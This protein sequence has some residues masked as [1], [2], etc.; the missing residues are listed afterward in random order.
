[1]NM[2]FDRIFATNAENLT[3]DETEATSA[4]VEIRPTSEKNPD[5]Q[6]SFLLFVADCLEMLLNCSAKLFG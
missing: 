5:L 6:Q 2:C 4:E 1:M 3:E